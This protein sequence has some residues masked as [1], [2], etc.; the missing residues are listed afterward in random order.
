MAF[1]VHTTAFWI[2]GLSNTW[3]LFGEDGSKQSH[4]QIPWFCITLACSTLANGSHFCFNFSTAHQDQVTF[5]CS[6]LMS[7]SDLPSSCQRLKNCK[8]LS[9][10]LA[11]CYPPPITFCLYFPDNK[12]ELC[13]AVEKGFKISCALQIYFIV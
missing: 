2:Q 11:R 12:A 3:H 5:F 6:T 1:S 7:R 10:P 13:V 9:S 4:G 8:A